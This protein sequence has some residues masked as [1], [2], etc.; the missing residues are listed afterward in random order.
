MVRGII[1][2]FCFL[3]I[4]SEAQQENYF[5][6]G[7]LAV[8]LTISPS[9]MLNQ[10]N[11]NAYLT[12]FFEGYLDERISFRGE[13]N[14]VVSGLND[15]SYYEKGFRTTAGV[16][17]HT[18]KNNLDAHVGMMP[19]IYIAR[20]TNNN[21]PTDATKLSIVPVISLNAGGAFYMW[22]FAHVFLNVTYSS[23]SYRKL[24]GNINGRADELMISLGLG[25]NINAIKK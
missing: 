20:L 24:Y 6:P 13:G 12:G 2:L 21:S 14:F 9:L 3:S 7:L 17:L 19:G 8:S 1:I 23:T 11:K 5:R 25:F 16:L 18:N 15:T 22:K 10:D 4:K